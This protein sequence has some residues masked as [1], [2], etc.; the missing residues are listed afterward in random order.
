MAGPLL[1]VWAV[2][3]LGH[4]LRRLK[5]IRRLNAFENPAPVVLPICKQIFRPP[6]CRKAT[7]CTATVLASAGDTMKLTYLLLALAAAL[8]IAE[9]SPLAAAE[10]EEG[11]NEFHEG[12]GENGEVGENGNGEREEANGEEE[13]NG[14]NGEMNEAE[15]EAEEVN[16]AEA[17]EMDEANEA[18]EMS[19]NNNVEGSTGNEVSGGVEGRTRG[20][21]QQGSSRFLGGSLESLL[22]LGQSVVGG[23]LGG[24]GNPNFGTGPTSPGFGGSPVG[25]GFG[26]SPVGPGF[27]G[28]PVGPGFGGSPVGPG[29]GGSIINPGLVGGSA[30]PG[31]GGIIGTPGVGGACRYSCRAPNGRYVCCKPGSCP[32]VRPTCP[33]VRDFAPPTPC[34][35]DF[36][37]FG[38]DKCCYDSCLQETVCK[39]PLGIGG[40]GR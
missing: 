31:F 37:C 8:V 39:P 19:E 1:C 4:K 16:E 35:S 22:N 28:S 34:S 40:F 23:F 32:P 12:N 36:Q 21:S 24:L 25:P 38:T 29:F 2:R 18:E 17:G 15:A 3:S 11:E 7:S 30:N 5:E 6:I 13:T 33:Q 27:G 10:N 20:N 26:G 9:A 14:G